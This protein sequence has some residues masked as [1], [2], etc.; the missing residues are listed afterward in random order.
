MRRRL[1]PFV[2]MWAPALACGGESTA[3][4]AELDHSL[5]STHYVYYM[6]R[7]DVVDTTWQ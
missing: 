3:P 7:G 5:A 1:A 2:G 6:A 4:S